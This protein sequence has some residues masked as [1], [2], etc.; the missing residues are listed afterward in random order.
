MLLLEW[1]VINLCDELEMYMIMLMLVKYII[2]MNSYNEHV[3]LEIVLTILNK[4]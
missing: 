3:F 2:C 1:S 4:Y